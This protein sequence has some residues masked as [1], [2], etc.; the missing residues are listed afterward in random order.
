MSNWQD[1]EQHADR[2]LEMFERGRLAEAETELRKA[3]EIDPDQGDWHFNLGLTLERIGRD[4]EALSSYEQASRLLTDSIDPQLAAGSACLRL[5]RFEDAIQWLEKVVAHRSSVESAWAMLIDANASLDDHEAAETAFYM[6]QDA[7]KEP[8]ANVLI[9]MSGSL[10]TRS[11]VDRAVWCAREALKIDSNVDGGRLRLA[12]ALVSSGQGQQ[13]SQILLQELRE[14]PGNVQAL[15]LHADVLAD[16]GRTN[17]A[18]MKLHRVLELEPANVDAHIRA[19]KFALEEQRWE[20]AFIAWGLVRRLDPSHPTACLHLAQSLLAMQRPTAARPL[21]QEYVELMDD[22]TA[23]I[24]KLAIS[25]LLLSSGESTL[26]TTLL[27]PLIIE[28]DDPIKVQWLKLLALSL[29]DEGKI[30]EGAAISRKVLRFD[31]NCI[32]SIHNLAL[33]TMKNERYRSAW[34]WV[35]RGLSIDPIDNDL[36]RLRSRLIWESMLQFVR[37]LF[38]AK[39]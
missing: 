27:K 38:I 12:S 7:L 34:G 36:R 6:A 35:R 25:E 39:R 32:A 21:L 16:A 14:D 13:A 29:F 18:L 5:G 31:P 17:E 26:V 8:S 11:L 3:L 19:G 28:D 4:G 9:S 1:A 23:P 22:S 15:L 30:D 24:E 2:A 33:A 37:K 10:L 20:E